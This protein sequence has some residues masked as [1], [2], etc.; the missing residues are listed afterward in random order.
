MTKEQMTKKVQYTYDNNKTDQ[1]RNNLSKL[2]TFNFCKLPNEKCKTKIKC[3]KKDV[4]TNDKM[5]R[6]TLVIVTAGQLPNAKCITIDG[7]IQKYKQ[8]KTQN[9]KRNI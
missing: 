9:K 4:R 1:W 5:K 7:K 8:T 6:C 2:T 3:K